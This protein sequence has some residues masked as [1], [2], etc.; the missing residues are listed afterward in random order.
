MDI[1]K[2]V[3]KTKEGDFNVVIEISMNTFPVKYE[4]SKD[5]GVMFVDR[6]I[7]APM[8]Y[9]YN[10]GFIPN[11]LSK[12]GDCLDVLVMA[13]YPIIVGAVITIRPVGVLLMQDESGLDEKILAVPIDKIDPSFKKIYDISDVEEVTKRKIHH[14]FEYYKKLEDNKWT[15]ITGWDSAAKAYDIINLAIKMHRAKNTDL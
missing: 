3:S 14:F 13:T 4:I 11:T 2:I 9:P 5:L 12:D 1:K 6:I 8:F 10:Y 7:Q 15:D